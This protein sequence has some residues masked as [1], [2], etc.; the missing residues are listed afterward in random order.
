MTGI[1]WALLGILGTLGTTIFGSMIAQEARGRLDRVPHAIL[2]LAARRL[3]PSQRDSSYQDDW[4]P[5]LTYILRETETRPLTRLIA[6][7]RYALGILAAAHRIS[8]Q[9]EL[10]ELPKY[11]KLN[12]FLIDP[13]GTRPPV[14]WYPNWRPE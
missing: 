12:I 5:E 10:P 9:L 8:R 14:L 6:G 11:A 3:T 7:T 13:D 1:L 4:L 2:R